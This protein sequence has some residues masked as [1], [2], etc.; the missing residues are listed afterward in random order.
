MKL[1]PVIC[2]FFF[3]FLGLISS[4]AL[5]LKCDAFV[6]ETHFSIKLP[7]GEN[8]ILPFP[9][10]WKITRFNFNAIPEID[11]P[12][13]DRTPKNDPSF[14][15]IYY[16]SL[17]R[18]INSSNVNVALHAM[19]NADGAPT[20]ALFP[21]ARLHI[22]IDETMV[23]DWKI[24]SQGDLKFEYSSILPFNW[25]GNNKGKI[26]HRMVGNIWPHLPKGTQ[27]Q[28]ISILSENSFIAASE[29]EYRPNHFLIEYLVPGDTQ[30][31]YHLHI[32][33]SW[34]KGNPAP[35]N[36]WWFDF[37]SR[38]QVD[39][40]VFKADAGALSISSTSRATRT[41]IDFFRRKIKADSSLV[42]ADEAGLESLAI[43]K[44]Q[45]SVR[46]WVA[47]LPYPDYFVRHPNLPATNFGYGDS[48]F[49]YKP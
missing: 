1:S 32:N 22:T 38:T 35:E 48:A 13:T 14:H 6:E 46:R 21:R 8:I 25:T 33:T 49:I 42:V 5:G 12:K 43:D 10:D 40:F 19:S 23:F 24:P 30:P 20:H 15:Q 31:I 37:L 2:S 18:F 7:R 41:M 9:A 28:K 29:R 17:G 36:T 44:M 45:D 26:L 11:L 39:A 47:P 3:I 27:L 34:S 4:R 16:S